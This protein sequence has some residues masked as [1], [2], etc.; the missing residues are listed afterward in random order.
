[1]NV[2]P[3][4]AARRLAAAMSRSSRRMVVRMR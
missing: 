4:S 1:V 3:V 2:R